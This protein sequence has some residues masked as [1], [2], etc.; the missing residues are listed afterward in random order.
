MTVIENPRHIRER[1]PDQKRTLDHLMAQDPEFLA[2]CEDYNACV[3][4]FRYWI[5]SEAP[6]TKS[7]TDE[8]R[9]LIR[10]LQE[11]IAQAISAQEPGRCD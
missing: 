2:L 3:D 10:E 11:E 8:Y 6:E 9:T 5:Q 7:R 4:A 1:F